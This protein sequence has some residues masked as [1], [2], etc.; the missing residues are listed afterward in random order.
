MALITVMLV[1]AV[2]TAIV[3]R[4]TL[5]NQVWIRQ[6]ESGASLAQA[7]QVAR[8][9]EHWIGLLLVKDTNDHDGHQDPWARPLPPFPVGWGELD[10]RIEDMQGRFNLN[11]LVTP[12]GEVAKVSLE[13]FRRLLRIL[14]LTPGIADAAVDWVDADALP[15]G[16]G[17][18]EDS[19]YMGRQ[20]PYKAANRPFHG[21][22]ELRLVRGV[23]QEAWQ[24]LRPHV[25]ALPE[26]TG[27]NVNT[28]TAEVLAA[29]VRPWGSPRQA[30][31]RGEEWRRRTDREPLASPE[32]FTEAALPGD[33]QEPVQGITTQTQFFRA[34]IRAQFGQVDH[35]LA[36]IYR[37][38]NNRAEVV[39]HRREIP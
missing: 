12:D 9:A 26:A 20:P 36:T 2:L 1:V 31:A 3:S 11:N 10:G 18:A 22:E 34:H 5:S 30:L 35:R 38:A 16:G 32:A 29:T 28:A 25:A 8:A 37:R 4:L 14:E 27:V 39:R 21:A 23:D 17:G 6:V 13:R 15:A 19:Y 24:R 33:P 7:R